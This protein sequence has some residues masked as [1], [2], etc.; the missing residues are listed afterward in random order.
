MHMASDVKVRRTTSDVWGEIDIVECTIEG[1]P[2]VL[3]HVRKVQGVW[4]EGGFAWNRDTLKQ[5]LAVLEGK[6]EVARAAL[7]FGELALELLC[8]IDMDKAHQERLARA[9]QS[10]TRAIR[11]KIKS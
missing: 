11:K 10:Q 1:A 3:G 7:F 8:E 9:E 6:L 2:H 4:Q 5:E